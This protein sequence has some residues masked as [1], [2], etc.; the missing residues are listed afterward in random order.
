M[1]NT[2]ERGRD[3]APKNNLEAELNA[4]KNAVWASDLPT[5]ERM[6]AMALAFR[7]ITPDGEWVTTDILSWMCKFSQRT[8]R[9]KCEVLV[10]KG[11]AEKAFSLLSP[12]QIKQKVIESKT[13]QKGSLPGAKAC[14][15][16][17]YETLVLHE[18]HYPVRREDGGEKVVAIC[19]NCHAEYHAIEGSS[20]YR[21]SDKA[22]GESYERTSA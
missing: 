22:R 13:F 21:F 17:S 3:C 1:E 15:W 2:Q 6:L 18:H 20:A 5:H 14:S 7:K 19:P 4:R 10:E 16:C 12:E 11:W 8:A 9:K